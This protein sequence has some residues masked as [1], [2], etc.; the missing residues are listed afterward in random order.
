M[1]VQK[2]QAPRPLATPQEVA[3]FLAVPESRLRQWRYLGTGP[4]YRK[5]ANHLVRYR[6]SDVEEWLDRESAV[7]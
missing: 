4:A 2:V 1:A 7:A 3:D 5:L 6:W